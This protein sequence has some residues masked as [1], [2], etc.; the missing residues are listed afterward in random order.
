MY[1]F[2]TSLGPVDLAFTDRYGGV[3]AA[4]Y[5]E[6]NLAVNGADTIEAKA[7]N[8]RR[9]LTDFAPGAAY[10]DLYQVHGREVADAQPGVRPHA[11]G[12]VTTEHD[13]VLLVRS[14]DCVPVLLADPDNGVIG[15]VH[16]GRRGMA[17]GVVPATLARMRELGA[18]ELTAWV[19]P[20]VCGKCYEVP[21][22][23]Q[24]EVAAL[25]PIS[26]A[27]TTWGTPSL[28]VGAGV[29]A[30]LDRAEV[31]IVDASRCTLESPDLYSYRRDG[32]GMSLGALIRIRSRR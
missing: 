9:V 25:E 16:A 5:D 1:S 6:L 21:A 28:D 29:R 26:R 24:D 23:M 20:Y 31:T 11:D 19:G 3:S 27:T 2:R 22:A 13:V 17:A 7:E 18:R 14:A 8:H 10:A 15:A 32:V 30:Q 12:I 4:P